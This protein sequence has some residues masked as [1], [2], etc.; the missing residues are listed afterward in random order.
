MINQVEDLSEQLSAAIRTAAREYIIKIDGAK[1]VFPL[2]DMSIEYLDEL[3]TGEK[4]YSVYGQTVAIFETEY[5]DTGDLYLKPVNNDEM[6]EVSVR[7]NVIVNTDTDQID[8]KTD[9]ILIGD[10][11]G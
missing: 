2:E 4:A 1:K 10:E 7:L 3:E 6:T 9:E 8:V 11:N 5:K